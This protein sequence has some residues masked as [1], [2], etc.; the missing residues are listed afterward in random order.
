MVTYGHQIFCPM[1]CGL[2]NPS[3]RAILV[4]F[5]RPICL[6]IAHSNGT[7]NYPLKAFLLAACLFPAPFLS[8]HADIIAQWNFNSAPPDSDIG[9]GSI[10]PSIGSGT[11]SMIGGVTPPST[12]EFSTGSTND[13]ASS[14][15]DSG[16]QTSHYPAQETG[17]RTA[18]VQFNV[19]TVGYSNIVVRWDQR[20]TSTASKYFSFQYTTNG[21]T[22]YDF[23]TPLIM[24]A[25]PSTA[26]YYE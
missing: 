8:A 21:N 1:N 9:T 15:D 5:F 24:R 12:G 16:W 10:T 2:L 14:T 25:A 7:V 4:L 6:F 22:F 20:V 13:P 3:K 18:G 19:S 17:D 23:G 26:S 11:A